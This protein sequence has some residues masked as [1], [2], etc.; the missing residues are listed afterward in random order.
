MTQREIL[1]LFASLGAI[2]TG[3]HVVYKSHKHGS[4]YVNKDA[5]YPHT[6]AISVLCRRIANDCALTKAGIEV[7]VGPAMGGIILSQWVAHHLSTF[8]TDEVLAV[9]AEKNGD[10]FI[11]KRGQDKLLKDKR[12]VVVE[13]V[14]TTGGSVKKVVQ[15]VR[16]CGGHVDCVFALCNRG[17]V[18][19]SMID[20]P[21]LCSLVNVTMDAFDPADCPLCR[22]HVPINTE[23]G[24]GAEFLVAH[25]EMKF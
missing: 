25:P 21:I 11:I 13:D 9:Y 6:R 8:G 17:G 15:A 4:T 16:D 1:D 7:V 19:A 18:T 3:T 24:H 14:L 22:G 20:A 2:I 10:D 5:I 23:V 12:V